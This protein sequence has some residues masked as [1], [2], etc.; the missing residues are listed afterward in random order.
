MKIT[1]KTLLVLA[2]AAFGAGCGY[3][4]PK[5]TMPSISQLSP[6]ST[7]AGSGSFQLEVDGANFTTGAKV[8][9]AG[10]AETTTFVNANKL[11]ASIPAAAIA[12]SGNVPV[13]V[14]NP[15][16]SGLY[17]SMGGATSTPMTFTVN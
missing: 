12:T 7:T 14:T 13:T 11:E 8:S 2:L 6:G 3:T 17:G 4:K 5:T 16:S 9:F 15:G 10:V 1:N